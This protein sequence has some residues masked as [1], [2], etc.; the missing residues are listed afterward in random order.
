[1]W[2]EWAAM[3]MGRLTPTLAIPNDIQGEQLT[4]DREI[5]AAFDSDPLV[6]TKSTV[7]LGRAG[8]GAVRANAAS[9]DRLRIPTLVFHGG[10]DT[11]VPPQHSLALAK[12]PTVER[13]LYPALR[14][15]TYNEPGGEAVISD[16]VDWLRRQ[17][18]DGSGPTP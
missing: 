4:Q 10:A 6:L 1:M 5:A 15:E 2:K 7:A 13:R 14:H 17:F 16:V 11:V 3:V 9:L 18:A 8:F 12:L